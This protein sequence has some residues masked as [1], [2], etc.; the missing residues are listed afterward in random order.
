MDVSNV[1]SLRALLSN[2]T[3]ATI[4]QSKVSYNSATINGTVMSI[5]RV[6]VSG[7]TA[8][9]VVNVTL[10]SVDATGL[11]TTT[12]VGTITLDAEG[13]GKL[14]YTTNPS[15]KG[16]GVAFP[17]G[18]PTSITAGMTVGVDTLTAT[19]AAFTGK[20]GKR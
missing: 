11:P 10:P 4:L 9:Q 16:F 15:P 17:A 20:G 3:G 5:F 1:V 18:F 13:S 2:A 12:I 8:G 19:I 6:N 14:L 7:G